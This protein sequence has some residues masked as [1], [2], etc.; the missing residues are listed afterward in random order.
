MAGGSQVSLHGSSP[1]AQPPAQPPSM[2]YHGT[3]AASCSTNHIACLGGCQEA[4]AGG[5]GGAGASFAGIP[6]RAHGEGY[7]PPP[8]PPKLPAGTGLRASVP[9]RPAAPPIAVEEQTLSQINGW[10]QRSGAK[11]GICADC[12]MYFAKR[13]MAPSRDCRPSCPNG[14]AQVE[15]NTPREFWDVGFSQSQALVHSQVALVHSQQVH[16]QSY[17][18]SAPDPLWDADSPP[19]PVARGRR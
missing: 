10:H 15:A 17:H 12:S 11:S 3:A 2:S 16:S 19:Q 14:Q 7:F 18:A 8:P 5:G 9:V 1:P 13:Q 4:W 6:K